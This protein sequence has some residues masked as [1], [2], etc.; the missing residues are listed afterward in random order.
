MLTLAESLLSK[1]L[2]R[3]IQGIDKCILIAPDLG[4]ESNEKKE[5]Y[6]LV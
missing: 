5:P 6:L 3:S 1:I 2:V 4:K